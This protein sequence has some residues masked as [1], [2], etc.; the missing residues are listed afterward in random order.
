[1]TADPVSVNLLMHKNAVCSHGWTRDMLA[2]T[3]RSEV[4][5]SLKMCY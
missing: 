2:K 1:M 5:M 3:L 4:S